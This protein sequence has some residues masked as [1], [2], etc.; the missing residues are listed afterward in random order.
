MQFEPKARADRTRP[1]CRP[2]RAL[3]DRQPR[4]LRVPGLCIR[5]LVT[6]PLYL[7]EPASMSTVRVGVGVFVLSPDGT[8]FITGTRI[9][10]LGAGEQLSLGPAKLGSPACPPLLDELLLHQ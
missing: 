8:K 6:G 7:P 4:R 3:G 1:P 2:P 5:P 9:G 10:S